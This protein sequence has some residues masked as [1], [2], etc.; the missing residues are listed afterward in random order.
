MM[1]RFALGLLAQSSIHVRP[2]SCDASV[3]ALYSGVAREEATQ[4]PCVG[5]SDMHEALEAR[6]LAGASVGGVQLLLLPVRSLEKAYMWVTCPGVLK[7]FAEALDRKDVKKALKT[8]KLARAQAL[9]NAGGGALFL[10]ELNFEIVGEVAGAITAALEQL[11]AHEE[12]RSR[13]GEQLVVVNDEDFSWFVRCAVPI[14]TRSRLNA[15]K[16]REKL[17][18]EEVLAADTLF[19]AQLSEADADLRAA[20]LDDPYLQVGAQETS[21]RGWFHAIYREY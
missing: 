13:L 20:L 16:I 5:V 6:A 17:W 7:R 18:Y 1:T 9:C 14:A 15:V 11:V 3:D 8:I 2:A 21:G 19:Y 10:E 4:W 12:T